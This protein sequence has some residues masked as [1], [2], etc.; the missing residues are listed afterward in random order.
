MVPTIRAA[1]ASHPI[2]QEASASCPDAFDGSDCDD[3][4]LSDGELVL[5]SSEKEVSPFTATYSMSATHIA[6]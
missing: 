5:D 2:S 4:H 1:P 3:A 6:F